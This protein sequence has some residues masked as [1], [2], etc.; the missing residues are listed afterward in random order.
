M[1]SILNGRIH[2]KGEFAEGKVLV[3]DE[4]ITG[5]MDLKEYDN[6]KKLHESLD[7]LD[8]KGAYIVPGFID[9]H[10]HG[11][12]GVD[13]MD[14]NHEAL[15]VISRGVAE[16]GVTAFLPTTMTMP[17]ADI[18]QAFVAVREYMEGRYTDGAMILGVHMEGPFINESFK[19]AQSPDH[20]ALPD[21]VMVEQYKEIIKI[22][23][24]APE[25]QGAME[26][27]EKYHDTINF[28]IGHTAATYEQASE[29]YSKG[30][31]GTTHL[32]NAMTGLHHREPGVVGAAMNCDCHAEVIA[33]NFHLNPVLYRLLEQ[34]K[35]LDKLLLVTDCMQAGG[36]SEGTYELGG[37]TVTVSNGQCR[38]SSGT[39]AGSVLKLNEGLRNFTQGIEKELADTICM[40][41][42]N[43]AEYLGVQDQMGTLDIG[44][45][46]NIVLMDDQ[47]T[48]RNTIVKGK[49]IYED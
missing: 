34:V 2:I 5:L 41:S 30:V 13:T 33:D 47:F 8:A 31:K 40:V 24:I 10:I 19:G 48:V 11:Y 38:L 42:L 18:E 6:F 36:L 45:W 16:N 21:E 28:N 39:I 9:V 22:I 27:I 17:K 4:K 46:A 43:Q 32:F 25:I 15:S 1:K 23:T 37:Q 49:M 20:I 35:G 44:K 12:K 14:G 29:A 26:L 3:Y 7:E